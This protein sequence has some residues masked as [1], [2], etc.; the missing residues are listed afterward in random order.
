MKKVYTMTAPF[1]LAKTVIMTTGS[2]VRKLNIEGE[3]RPPVTASPD[4]HLRWLLLQD[5]K[6][7]W[8][9]VATCAEEALFLTTFASK[10]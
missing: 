10:V 2:Q 3:D 6:S 4:A 8:S 1:D 9:A 5:A 7:Q